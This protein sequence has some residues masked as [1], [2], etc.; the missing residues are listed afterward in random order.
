M[1]RRPATMIDEVRIEL[2]R[3][4]HIGMMEEESFNLYVRHLRKSIE[5]SH[6]C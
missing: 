3:P 2:P 1:G 6:A 5:T 4:R